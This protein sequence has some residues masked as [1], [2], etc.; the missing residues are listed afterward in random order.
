MLQDILVNNATQTIRRPAAY[1]RH[2]LPAEAAGA[3]LLE[4]SSSAADSAGVMLKAHYELHSNRSSSSNEAIL[5]LPSSTDVE[6]YPATA[7][8]VIEAPGRELASGRRSD[9]EQLRMSVAQPNTHECVAVTALLVLARQSCSVARQ[10]SLKLHSYQK[11]HRIAVLWSLCQPKSTTSMAN[12]W[13][14]HNP[15]IFCP[16]TSHLYTRLTACPRVLRVC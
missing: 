8:H 15:A 16:H 6:H 9:P 13:I 2:L 11:M 5:D 1:Y 4:S 10:C 12:S 7:S 3:T 14:V